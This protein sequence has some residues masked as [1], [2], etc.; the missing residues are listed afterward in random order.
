VKLSIARG[1]SADI[2]T[3]AVANQRSQAG[4]SPGVGGSS[5]RKV[6]RPRSTGSRIGA[7]RCASRGLITASRCSS[8]SSR[9]PRGARSCR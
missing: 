5:T 8:C 9:S 7:I 1:A 2:G 6:V 4:S 3:S